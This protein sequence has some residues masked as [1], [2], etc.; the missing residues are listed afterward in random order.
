LLAVTHDPIIFRPVSTFLA[1]SQIIPGI[2]NRS[3]WHWGLLSV[4]IFHSFFMLLFLSEMHNE[5]PL[6]RSV[7]DG[8]SAP[9]F[10]VVFWYFAPLPSLLVSAFAF[11][12]SR[13][14]ERH[15]YESVRF[16]IISWSLIGF[17][18]IVNIIQSTYARV[19]LESTASGG[20]ELQRIL[21]QGWILSGL[22]TTMSVVCTITAI[23]MLEYRR[24][25]IRDANIT[26]ESTSIV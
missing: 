2:M 6:K 18:A 19:L 11:N 7:H 23:G 5:L 4:L 25:E 10:L 16:G 14:G 15:G 22:Y 8:A 26:K 24:A 12:H 1:N 17:T 3:L 21:H 13:L 20:N 9:F